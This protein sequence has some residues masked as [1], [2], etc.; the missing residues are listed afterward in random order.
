[1]VLDAFDEIFSAWARVQFAV[2]DEVGSNTA[3]VDAP[4]PSGSA[5]VTGTDGSL[6]DV[7]RRSSVVGAAASGTWAVMSIPPARSATDALFV[8]RF[9]V[10]P[11]GWRGTSTEA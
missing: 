8:N 11:N 1:V 10:P 6:K 9:I 7:P 2:Y 3:L 4:P 5:L